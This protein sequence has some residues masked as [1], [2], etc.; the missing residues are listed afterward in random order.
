MYCAFSCK[1]HVSWRQECC[2]SARALGCGQRTHTPDPPAAGIARQVRITLRN[3]NP[4]APETD[5][6]TEIIAIEVTRHAR[7]PE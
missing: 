4:P 2:V 5:R 1:P 6:I 7:P 3:Q